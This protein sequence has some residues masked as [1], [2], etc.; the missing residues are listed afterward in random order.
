MAFRAGL[1]NFSKGVLSPELQGRVDVEAYNAGIRQGK[2]VLILKHGGLTKRP[3]T[4]LVYEIKDGSKRLLP[5][6]GAY[7]ASYALLMGQASMR[8]AT[9]GGIVLETLQT[10]HGATN[11]NPVELN[12]PFHGLS[13]GD[14]VFI[15]SVGG[16]VE[17]NERLFTITVAGPNS[18]TLNGVDGRGFG[19]FTGDTGGVTNSAPPPSPPPPPAVPPPSTS[20]PTPPLGGDGGGDF[21]TLTATS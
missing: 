19:V 1:F 4:R 18:F 8:V 11:A 7:E 14:E 20:P 5:F 3:G 13:T 10:I 15:A 2:N 21:Q 17:L 6:E 12:V 9:G 16:M